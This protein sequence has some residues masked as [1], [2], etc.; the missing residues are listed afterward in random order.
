[1]EQW[2][3]LANKED[4]VLA[5]FATGNFN[6]AKIN[7]LMTGIENTL[8]NLPAAVASF[9]ETNSQT[10]SFVDEITII[11][12]QATMGL[13]ILN[14]LMGSSDGTKIRMLTTTWQLRDKIVDTE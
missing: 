7:E 5:E 2:K 12:R 10:K 4:E 3:E 14:E 6:F 13:D 11:R 1:M 8:A 9:N